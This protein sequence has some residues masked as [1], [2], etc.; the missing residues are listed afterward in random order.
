MAGM[1][2]GEGEKDVSAEI[3]DEEQ[4]IGTQVCL[5]AVACEGIPCTRP[6]TYR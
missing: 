6:R 3:E 5:W 4:L 1:G 2:E